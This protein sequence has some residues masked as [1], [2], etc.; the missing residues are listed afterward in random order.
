M[1]SMYKKDKL[2]LLVGMV[3]QVR[4]EDSERIRTMIVSTSISRTISVRRKA[5]KNS[6]TGWNWPRLKPESGF[7]F[8]S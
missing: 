6:P 3:E 5:P 4:F 7:R 8:L 1:V 2:R